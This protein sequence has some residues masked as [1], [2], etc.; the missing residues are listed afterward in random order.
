MP[1]REAWFNLVPDFLLT[2]DG[3]TTV[4][5]TKWKRID[6]SLDNASDKYGLNQADFY[7][8]F[9]YGERYLGGAGDLLLVYPKSSTFT[10]PL[11][12]FEFS[13]TLRLW[14]VPF[15]LEAGCVVE[16]RPIA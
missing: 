14:V 4:L 8:L 9:A 10:A 2:V 7:Q 5:D 6:Q 1:Q 3:C 13:E 11:P 15:D 16:V 12:A